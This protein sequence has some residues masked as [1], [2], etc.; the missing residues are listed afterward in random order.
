[1]TDFI[2]ILYPEKRMVPVEKIIT[3]ASDGWFNSA[4]QYKCEACGQV[5]MP[6]TCEC[7]EYSGCVAVWPEG[8]T[9]PETLEDCIEFLSD[10]GVVTFAKR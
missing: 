5:G 10:L 4:P 2:K 8:E 3:W 6:L 9:K 7:S 1:M